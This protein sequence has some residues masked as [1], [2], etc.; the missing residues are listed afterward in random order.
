M[1]NNLLDRA[2]QAIR[3]K[4]ILFR[5]RSS[6]VAYVITGIYGSDLAGVGTTRLTPIDEVHTEEYESLSIKKLEN[7]IPLII[8]DL[9]SDEAMNY[10]FFEQ[11][12]SLAQTPPKCTPPGLVRTDP[13][14]LGLTDPNKH[15]FR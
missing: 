3:E 15:D 1:T 8:R 10:H 7:A 14:G 4:N 2:N 5:S 11:E 13:S 6:G 12:S 9:S